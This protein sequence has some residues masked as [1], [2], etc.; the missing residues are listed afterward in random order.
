MDF[1][2]KE[3]A[4]L[5][6]CGYPPFITMTTEQIREKL[7]VLHKKEDELNRKIAKAD[8]TIKGC[9]KEKEKW[10]KQVSKNMKYRN[11]LINKL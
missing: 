11:S 6:N 2:Y 8:N 1:Y 7:L 4:K 10:A 5:Q 9:R 3:F